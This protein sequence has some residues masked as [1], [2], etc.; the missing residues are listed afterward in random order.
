MRRSQHMERPRTVLSPELRPSNELA[1]LVR[2]LRWIGMEEEA[3]DLCAELARRRAV[4]AVGV[5]AP[6]RETD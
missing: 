6:S 5:I 3:E 4:D 2:K 1:R